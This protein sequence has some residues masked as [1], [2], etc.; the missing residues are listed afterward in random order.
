MPRLVGQQIFGIALGR[1][2]YRPRPVA[3]R[4]QWWRWSPARWQQSR[5][6]AHRW[7]A[8]STL[9]RLKLS[10]AELT[11]CHKISHAGAAIEGFFVDLCLEVHAAPPPQISPDLDVTDDPLHGQ[12]EGRFSH[13]YYETLFAALCVLRPASV[14]RQFARAS[15]GSIRLKLLKIGRHSATR[16]IDLMEI[17]W[18]R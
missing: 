5:P 10:R 9:N 6:I 18:S 3:P 8:K 4:P 16:D 12:P 1:R 17:C 13:G 15:W 14:G 2:P 7:P 11:R